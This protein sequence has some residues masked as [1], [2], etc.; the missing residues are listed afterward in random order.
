MNISKGLEKVQIVI[1]GNIVNIP[2]LTYDN[3]TGKDIK[4]RALRKAIDSLEKQL[5]EV[6]SD[7]YCE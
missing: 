7:K 5:R 2:V 3:D 1:E 6:S 4:I